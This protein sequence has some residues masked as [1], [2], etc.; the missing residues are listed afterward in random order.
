MS[1]TV[2][3]RPL[4]HVDELHEVYELEKLV[5]GGGDAVPIH[6]MITAVRNG[7]LV[8]GAY[9]N[10]KLIG[11]SYSFPG[12]V[13]GKGYLCS[14]NLGIHPDYQEKGIGAKM[15]ER[16][17]VEALEM[18][19]KLVTWT[20]DPLETRNAFLN[21]SKLRAICHTYIENSYGE[22]TDGL[23]AGLPTDRFQVDW[24]IHSDHVLNEHSTHTHSDEVERLPFET[25]KSGLT[26][27]GDVATSRTYESEQIWVPVPSNF[28]QLK[29]KD[30]Q[31]ALNW[32]MKTRSLFQTLFQQGYSAVSL[33]R[34]KD[35]PVHHYVL[36]KKESLKIN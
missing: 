33:E 35:G 5:W 1:S 3:I 27:L 21:L 15:K 24:W 7:G 17:R 14:H 4:E 34:S 28:Q 25:T 29:S 22:I 19:Y 16:Q 9:M 20:Y 18:G 30:L 2:T 12:Y 23:N 6:Q 36:V 8:I 26:M 10:E 31:L 11:F 13:N 32:R